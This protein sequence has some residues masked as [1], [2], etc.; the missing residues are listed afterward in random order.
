MIS[1]F[2][3][4]HIVIFIY[5]GGINKQLVQA[6]IVLFLCCRSLVLIKMRKKATI[7][8]SGGSLD[9]EQQGNDL[10]IDIAYLI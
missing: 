9:Q 6:N 2:K 4:R 5:L 3:K 10:V 8:L 7:S 1:L